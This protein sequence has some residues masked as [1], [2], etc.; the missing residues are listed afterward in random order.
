MGR[1]TDRGAGGGCG[2]IAV[3][4]VRSTPVASAGEE[5]PGRASRSRR[6]HVFFGV[7][8]RRLAPSSLF[9]RVFAVN[10]ALLIVATVVLAVSPATVSFPVKRNQALVLVLGLLA[11]LAANAVLLRISLA[12]LRDLAKLMR[13]IDL[14]RPGQRLDA[15][16]ALELRAVVGTFNQMLDRL[17]FERRSSSTRV[18][19]GL[20]EERRRIAAELHDEVGQGLTALLLQ[21]KDVVEEAPSSLEP[22]LAQAQALARANVD[23]VRRIARQLRPTVLDDLGLAYAL[24]ALVDVFDA[25]AEI[26]F[27]RRIDVDAVRLAPAVELAL[28]RIAQEALTNAVRHSAASRVT[29]GLETIEGGSRVR[30]SV[31][32]DGRGMI[33]AADLE[34]GGVRGMR[35]RALAVEVELR[36]EA[37]L[38]EG[39]SVVAT[40]PVPAA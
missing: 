7:V 10:A 19:G 1:R 37:R 2:T 32:D 39:M 14:L 24:R 4:N 11:I 9:W 13:R 20:E 15:E 27:V 26:E 3:M 12:P 36:I 40:G 6:A 38:G 22:R 33:Y 5:L 29:V 30:L 18:V 28:Y 16:G 31:R 8:R 17:E 21:L 23:E 34:S 25:S 35:E